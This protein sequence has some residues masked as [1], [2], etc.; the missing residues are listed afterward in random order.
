MIKNKVLSDSVAL[1]SVRI[2]TILTSIVFTMILSRNMPLSDV[3]L[4]STGNLIINTGTLLSAFGL[5]DAVNFY[6]NGSKEHERDSYINTIFA[7]FVVCG[8]TVAVVIISCRDLISLYFHNP[9]LSAVY[10]YIAFRPFLQNT[11]QGLQNLQVSIGNAKMVAIKNAFLSI[12][13]MV[14]VLLTVIYTH[15]IVTVFI[16]MLTVEI[17]SLLFYY[18]ILW[19][20]NVF[21]RPCRFDLFKLKEI[22]VFC[23]PLG[24]YIQ[25]NALSRDVDKYVI[26]FYESTEMLAIYSN[27]STK[28][29]FDLVAGPLLTLTIPL[30][31]KCI[32][33]EEYEDGFFVY[34]S[35]I[36]VCYIFTFTLATICMILGKASILFLYGEKYIVGL[37][38]FLIYIMVDMVNFINYALVLTA[39]GKT[40]TLVKVSSVALFGNM[41]L[42]FVFYF[43]FGIV[44]P[45]IATLTI[46]IVTN[47]CLLMFSARIFGRNV[48]ELFDFRHF[49]IF[50]S[51]LFG[52]SLLTICA[53]TLLEALGVNYIFILFVLGISATGFVIF[54]NINSLKQSFKCIN[55]I[56]TR[57]IK[58][59]NVLN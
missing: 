50:F 32:R 22:L 26:G 6:Y 41:L 15:D 43:L 21:V 58:K 48:I 51:E 39:K 53:R 46:A 44:G 7:L 28:L 55:E 1:A 25:T 4:Y 52:V 17:I 36:K 34:K 37:N 14:S 12:S 20:N 13:K 57:I 30:I 56:N 3:G 47:G 16:C 38:I 59:A 11:I 29:P 5:I 42:N 33:S 49:A 19:I 24:L 18:R 9:K 8:I 2:L 40:K 31:T 10:I 35:Y 54:L 45:A 27:C 23:I